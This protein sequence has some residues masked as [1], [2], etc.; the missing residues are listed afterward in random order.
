M[1]Q[2]R[3]CC[4]GAPDETGCIW[5]TKPVIM[6]LQRAAICYCG[7]SQGNWPEG[8]IGLRGGVNLIIIKRV[9]VTSDVNS[10][11][12]RI[13]TKETLAM[14]TI[15]FVLLKNR[16]H[17][18]CLQVAS[19]FTCIY[20]ASILYLYTHSMYMYVHCSTCTSLVWPFETCWVNTCEL[21][22]LILLFMWN[23]LYTVLCKKK[24]K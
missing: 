22:F 5:F 16:P 20:C 6:V 7:D 2:F 13:Q 18:F 23:L 9:G 1:G 4:Q 10:T 14:I 15:L 21:G 24:A 3:S 19:C 8:I 12:Y 11:Y 17:T